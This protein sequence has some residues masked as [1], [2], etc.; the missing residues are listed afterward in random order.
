MGLIIDER[1]SSFDRCQ[2]PKE[3]SH[4]IVLGRKLKSRTWQMELAD[5][6]K[7][8]LGGRQSTSTDHTETGGNEIEESAKPVHLPHLRIAG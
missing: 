3:L 1:S 8:A 6:T 4:R 2:M 5:G 7:T